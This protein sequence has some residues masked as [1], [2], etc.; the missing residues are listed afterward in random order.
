MFLLPRVQLLVLTLNLLKE[1]VSFSLD[2]VA[3]E[4]HILEAL[5]EN[6][7]DLLHMAVVFAEL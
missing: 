4:H 7:F 5:L 2:V 6:A 3:L 1:R